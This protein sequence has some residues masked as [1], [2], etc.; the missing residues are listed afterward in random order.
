MIR[1]CGPL[2]G[3]ENRQQAETLAERKEVLSRGLL[4]PIRREGRKEA[5]N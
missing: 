2:E 1:V 3:K 4:N 5:R